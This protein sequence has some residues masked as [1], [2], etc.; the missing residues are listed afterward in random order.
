M[1]ENELMQCLFRP[2]KCAGQ[3]QRAVSCERLRAAGLLALFATE[4]RDLCGPVKVTIDLSAVSDANLIA[5]VTR[6]SLKAA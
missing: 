1:N 6:R 2:L 5:K 4:A 3:S